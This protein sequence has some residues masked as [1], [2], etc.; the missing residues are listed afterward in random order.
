MATIK[1]GA[2]PDGAVVTLQLLTQAEYPV[3]LTG[4]D[5]DFFTRVT[6]PP[7]KRGERAST[8]EMQQDAGQRRECR[9]QVLAPRRPAHRGL[10][11]RVDRDEHGGQPAGAIAGEPAP[12]LEHEQDDSG[13]ENQ[14]CGVER[15]RVFARQ[16]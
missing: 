4:P 10:G 14:V 1:P 5:A 16:P 11:R 3:P 12:E 9:P 6:I 2:F 8:V 13:E 7:S 15:R